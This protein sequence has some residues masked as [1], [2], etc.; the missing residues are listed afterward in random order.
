M[1]CKFIVTFRLFTITFHCLVFYYKQMK[2]KNQIGSWYR[3]AELNI[4]IRSD[5]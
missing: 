2:T 4:I 1:K 5:C 3:D